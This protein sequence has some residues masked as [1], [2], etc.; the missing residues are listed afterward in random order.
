MPKSK[1]IVDIPKYRGK[2]WLSFTNFPVKA[3][4]WWLGRKKSVGSTLNSPQLLADAVINATR[5]SEWIWPD[6]PV[7]FISDPHADTDA[8]IASL[9]ASGGI[10]KTG[11]ADS[12]FVLS[13]EGK[14]A[15]FVIGG[16]CF[17]KGPENLRL[18]R[19]I[20]NL[21]SVAK[22]KLLAGNHDLRLFM[23]IHSVFR[24]RDFS[25]EHF[26][27]R[28]GA[29]AVPLLKE[30]YDHY[31]DEKIFL[32]KTP[33]HEQC[34]QRLYPSKKWFDEF[35][36]LAQWTMSE[37]A[38]ERE[39]S[40]IRRKAD[41]FEDD[42]VEVG[43]SLRKVYMS[44]CKCR[45]LFL[46]NK[47]EYSWFYRKMKI[48][49]REG[50]F[51]FLHAGIDDRI[52]A[53]ID[54]KGIA[55]INDLFN[56]QVNGDFFEFYYGSVANTIRTKY[57]EVDRPLSSQGVERIHRKGIHALV[58]GHRNLCHGQRIMLRTGMLHIE[59]DTTM[60]CNS[61]KKEGL[62]GLGAGVTIVRPE[63]KVIGI[64]ADYP[65]A[66]VFMPNSLVSF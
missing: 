13:A 52:A 62:T 36:K 48:L 58:H 4:A 47:G 35:P 33:N 30:V 20:K 46:K 1:K 8:F 12:D 15:L 28:M 29:K 60:D 51:L 25:T 6:K 43:L 5:H 38:V 18:L 40:R 45:E 31:L 55:H 34:K 57:R 32:N 44:V 22:V 61:R 39:V 54:E 16:D 14:E 26:F 24:E 27:I 64:S 3:Q 53:L 11:P 49:H 63:G 42:C 65:F 9:V 56:E 41:K 21:T 66:K 59:S 50:S 17:D 37:A 19:C 2:K 7:Y 23:G 10:K